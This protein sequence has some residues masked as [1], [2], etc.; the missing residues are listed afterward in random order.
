MDH[1]A[2]ASLARLI[3]LL[4]LLAQTRPRV[5]IEIEQ[6]A[7]TIVANDVRRQIAERLARFSAEDVRIVEALTE[8]LDQRRACLPEPDEDL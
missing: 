7:N 5:V 3:T 1:Q 6:S 2:H 4:Q 8:H